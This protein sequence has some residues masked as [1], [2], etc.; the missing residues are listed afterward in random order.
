MGSVGI[1]MHGLMMIAVLCAC[2][3]GYPSR[4]LVTP[5]TANWL[6]Y[7]TGAL[8]FALERSCWAYCCGVEGA[9]WGC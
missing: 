6:I 9:T 3:L 2:Y 5:I 7:L 1:L 8:L 4:L